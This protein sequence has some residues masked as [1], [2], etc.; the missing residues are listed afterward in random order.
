[1]VRKVKLGEHT[2]KAAVDR[3]W[4]RNQMHRAGLTQRGLAVALAR[5]TGDKRIDEASL[6][7]RLRGFIRWR[8]EEIQALAHVFGVPIAEVAKAVGGP[9]E[10]PL[11]GTVDE[12][13]RVT[14]HVASDEETQC[15]AFNTLNALAGATLTVRMCPRNTVAGGRG[16]YVV[17]LGKEELYLR[18]VLDRVGGNWVL[19]NFLGEPKIQQATDLI[20]VAKALHLQF[21]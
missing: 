17:Q 3:L 7:R 12:I 20:F 11:T 18:Q 8:T 5:E 6:S 9:L 14:F 1:M 16:L 21:P 19:A 2:L 15:V 13:G 4:F 10:T